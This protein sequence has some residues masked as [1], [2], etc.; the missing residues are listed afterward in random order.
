MSHFSCE[1]KCRN[2]VKI[3]EVSRNWNLLYSQKEK[4][5]PAIILELAS[6]LFFLY[7]YLFLV[8]VA[9]HHWIDCKF[10]SQFI[11]FGNISSH[12]PSAVIL[13]PPAYEGRWEGNIFSLSVLCVCVW[14]GGG[15]WSEV[16][17]WGRWGWVSGPL[18]GGGG[19]LLSGP[20]SLVPGPFGIGVG[21]PWSTL[22]IPQPLHP[23]PGLR[24]HPS[25]LHGLDWG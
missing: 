7:N 13:L 23:W 20:Q 11:D 9:K 15:L 18:W 12:L 16:P 4:Y 25:H 3:T 5:E 14:G 6:Q 21:I 1:F 19:S 8:W 2:R 24:Y 17:S 10:F 22:E